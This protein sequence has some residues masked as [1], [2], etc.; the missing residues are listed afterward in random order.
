M[1]AEDRKRAAVNFLRLARDGNRAA[2]EALVAA[3]ARHHNPYFPAGMP[4]L[5][6][7]IGAAAKTSPNRTTEVKRVLADGDYVV[8]HSHVRQSPDV[9]GAAV[10]HIFRFDD[11]GRIAELWDIGQPIPADNPNSD[12]MF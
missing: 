3:G 8:V 12:G 11:G 1:N 10:I 2:A 9:P 6:D 7:A 4:A 5:L